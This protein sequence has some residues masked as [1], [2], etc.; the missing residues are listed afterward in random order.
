[1]TYLAEV[2]LGIWFV[3]IVLLTVSTVL[4]L[5]RDYDPDK[6]PEIQTIKDAAAFNPLGFGLGAAILIVFWPATVTYNLLANKVK[7]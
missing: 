3:G 5:H 6:Y 7:L 1:M 2:L 4:A